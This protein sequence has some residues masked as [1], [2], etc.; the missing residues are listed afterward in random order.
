[1][2]CRGWVNFFLTRVPIINWIIGYQ[3]GFI[4]GDI[5]SGITVAIMHIPQGKCVV[6]AY[7]YTCKSLYKDNTNLTYYTLYEYIHVHVQ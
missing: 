1:M 2:T 5:I 4:V 7:V 6:S 3:P